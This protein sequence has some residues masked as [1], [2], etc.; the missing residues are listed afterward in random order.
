LGVSG[1]VGQHILKRLEPSRDGQVVGIDI[2]TPLYAPPSLKFYQL[3]VRQPFLKEVLAREKIDTVVHLAFVLGDTGDNRLM[4]DINVNGTK[5]VLA[6]AASA[7]VSRVVLVTS[8]AVYGA[9]SD[10]PPMITEDTPLRGHPAFPY[11]RNQLAIEKLAQ[12]FISDNERPVVTTL[13][14]CVVY[15]GRG[16]RFFL[17]DFLRKAPFLPMPGGANPRLQFIHVE[18]LARAIFLAA[19][20]GRAG[21][22]NI[23]STD[24]ISFLQVADILGKKVVY[25]PAT[26]AYT[27]LEALQYLGL[28]ENMPPYILDFISRNWVAD[29]SKAEAELGFRARYSSTDA[30]KSMI[31]N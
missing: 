13:R 3:D 26:F 22:Y 29:G 21:A 6:S 20:K 16:T 23:V 9:N 11:L 19:E 25:A 31:T 1:Y 4:H 27:A 15:G 30:L 2:N 14:P 10:N 18:D 24:T 17:I 28:A 8:T 12:K 7:G 5:N